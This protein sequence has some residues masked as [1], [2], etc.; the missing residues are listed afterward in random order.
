MFGLLPP[1]NQVPYHYHVRRES[2]IIAISGEAIEIVEG[3]EYPFK[4]GSVCHIA[5]GEKHT[6]VNRSD[7]DF[8]YLEFFTCPPVSADFVEVH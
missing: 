1:G 2:V 5:A 8:R 4:S 6:T 7:K 3:Q